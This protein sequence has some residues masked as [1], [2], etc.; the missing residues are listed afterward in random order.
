MTKLELTLVLEKLEELTSVREILEE[1]LNYIGK[2]ETVDF[3]EH[4]LECYNLELVYVD[5]MGADI[6]ER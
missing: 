4:Y 5:E 6:Q 3:V 1:L 2:E